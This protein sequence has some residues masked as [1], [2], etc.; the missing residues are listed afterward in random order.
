M[1]GNTSLVPRLSPEDEWGAL[2]TGGKPGRLRQMTSR[3][4]RR[5]CDVGRR[6]TAAC[7]RNL[8]NSKRSPCL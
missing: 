8:L 3:K 1:T 7:P 4:N 5:D 6:D 2:K